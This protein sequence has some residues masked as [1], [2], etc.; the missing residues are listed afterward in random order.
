MS[1]LYGKGTLTEIER[2]KKYKIKFSGGKDPLTGRVYTSENRIPADARALDENGKPIRPFV[3]YGKATAEQKAKFD[4]WQTPVRYYQ[5]KETFLGTKRQAELRIEEIRRELNGEK[6]PNAD[7]VV[8]CDWCEQYLSLRESRGKY[9]PSTLRLD[10]SRSRHL[11]N[12]L[13]TMRVV[14]ITPAVVDSLYTSLR[15]SGLGDTALYQCH[16]LLKRVMKYAVDNNLIIRN[17]VDRA[18]APRRPKPKR[19]ALSTEEAIRLMSV[20]SSGKPTANKV[21]V[22]L[23]LS[24]GARLGE[25][26]GL[27]WGHVIL[28]GPKPFVHIIQQHTPDNKRTPL[29]TDKDESPQGRIVPLDAATVSALRLWKSEQRILLNDLGVE[30]GTGTPIVTSALG[31]WQGHSKFQKWWRDFCV[32]NGF[33]RWRSDDGRVVVDLIVGDESSLYSDAIVEW[34]DA[35]GWPCDEKGRR[36]S[37]SYKRPE[38]NRH[39]DGLNYH[40]LR[41]THF[42][43]RLAEGMDLPTAQALGGWS[44]PEMLLSVYAHPVAENIWESAGFMDNLVAKQGA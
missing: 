12:G 23:G 15:K 22:Y 30:Q 8:F 19:R 41:H 29:K 32:Q 40:E 34:R 9:R 27:T 11:L 10:R 28:D 3:T 2:G 21:C 4:R 14:D 42:T 31:R 18:E 7:S 24:L 5:I 1:K 17:P 16:K 39:Y 13:G 44:S 20:A 36:Y 33:G 38:V 43:M 35:D 6:A 37:R 26:L 25:I